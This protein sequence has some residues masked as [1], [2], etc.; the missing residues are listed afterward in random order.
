MNPSITV[1]SA[2]ILL[3]SVLSAQSKVIFSHDEVFDHGGGHTRI[4]HLLSARTDDPWHAIPSSFPH[5]SKHHILSESSIRQCVTHIFANSVSAQ[6]QAATLAAF[7]AYIGLDAVQKVLNG[8]KDLG[9]ALATITWN[10]GNLIGGPLGSDRAHDPGAGVDVEILNV[11][12]N[13]Q[14]SL[15]RECENELPHC[16]ISFLESFRKL[17]NKST[18]VE[19]ERLSSKAGRPPGKYV[20]KTHH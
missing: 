13:E 10:P 6:Q 14:K 20:V 9:E 16:T 17:I 8:H 3:V 7:N 15:I 18:H 4:A 11:L 12:N 19:W 1:L 5:G 2:L